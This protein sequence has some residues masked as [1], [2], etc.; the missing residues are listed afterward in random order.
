V[1]YLRKPGMSPSQ[2]FA[3]AGRFQFAGADEYDWDENEVRLWWD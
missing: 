3:L 1:L 2:L